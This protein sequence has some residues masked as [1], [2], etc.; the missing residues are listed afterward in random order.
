MKK[1]FACGWGN[2]PTAKFCAEC[3]RNFRVRPRAGMRA[4]SRPEDRSIGKGACYPHAESIAQWKAMKARKNKASSTAAAIGLSV[5]VAA[6]LVAWCADSLAEGIG[7]AFG[8]IFITLFVAMWFRQVG[9]KDYYSVTHAQDI[10]GQHRCI[11][12]GGRGIWRRTP[13]KTNS[14]VCSCSTCK[15]ELFFE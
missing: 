6:I 8:I 4:Q 12:C 2:L 3:G 9:S 13:Y 15:T 7:V 10:H 1:C 5:G 11:F 14:T